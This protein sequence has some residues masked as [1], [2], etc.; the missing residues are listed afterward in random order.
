EAVEK[1]VRRSVDMGAQIMA[2]GTRNGAFYEPSLVTDVKEDMPLFEEEV[3]GPVAP[4]IVVKNTDEAVE[5]VNNSEFGLGV[6]VFTSDIK[7]AEKLAH[8]FSDGAVFINS[9]VKSDP[10]LPFGGTKNSGYGRELSS[11]GIR[12]FVNAKTIYVNR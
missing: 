8:E 12:E 4:V 1:Q 11:Q 2:G 10:R 5:L 6:S 9:L 7:R 3:F